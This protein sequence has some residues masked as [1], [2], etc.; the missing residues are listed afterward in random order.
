MEVEGDKNES[1]E[2]G[3]KVEEAQDPSPKPSLSARSLP[4]FSPSKGY[5]GME[6]QS[7]R[8]S[9][10]TSARSVDSVLLTPAKFMPDGAA[11]A[12]F[13]QSLVGP[14]R[15]RRKN[16]RLTPLKQGTKDYLASSIVPVLIEGLTHLSLIR[17]KAG[18]DVPGPEVWLAQF[19]LERS[20]QREEYEIRRI[21]AGQDVGLDAMPTEE[22]PRI[23]KTVDGEAQTVVKGRSAEAALQSLAAGGGVAAIRSL[24][25]G[26]GDANDI[27]IN[28]RV[29]GKLVSSETTSRLGGEVEGSAAVY[30]VTVK[31]ISDSG[32]SGLDDVK[33]SLKRSKV[34]KD[35]DDV[36][37]KEGLVAKDAENGG[38]SPP[39][40][41][42]D[43]ALRS[44]FE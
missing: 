36:E 20:P 27:N 11:A 16:R 18:S 32:K 12:A 9:K 25:R 44:I 31:G 10:P 22:F 35:D 6:P 37:E 13:S 8:K 39:S 14:L 2:S 4:G 40:N 33:A 19:L 15:S 26:H 41:D 1:N 24:A 17:P 3:E 23:P 7:G 5:Q 34:N 21:G 42:V 28:I 43:A 29:D 38:I 30:D